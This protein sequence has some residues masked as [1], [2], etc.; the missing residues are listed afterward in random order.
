LKKVNFKPLLLETAESYAAAEALF[1]NM[2]DADRTEMLLM[3]YDSI[4]YVTDSINTSAEC[5]AAYTDDGVLLGIGGIADAPD[6]GLG[7]PIWFIATKDINRNRKQLAHYGMAIIKRY[8][9]IYGKVYN[10][11]SIDNLQAIRYIK[12]A[13]ATIYP[14]QRWGVGGALF[15]PFVIER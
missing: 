8:L 5:F 6:F 7:K 4:E 1:N 13:G 3:G 10:Y 15:V 12:K 11:I 9:E 2:R 14:P